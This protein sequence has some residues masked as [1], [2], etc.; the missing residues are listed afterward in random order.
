MSTADVS[1][2]AQARL[3]VTSALM[4][5][6]PGGAYQIVRELMDSGVPFDQVLLD[7]VAGAHG[8]FGTRWQVGDYSIADE[9]AATGAVETL[10]A[11]LGGSF[12]LPSNGDVIVVAAA[13][14]DHH[15]LPARLASTYLTSIGFRIRYL[16]PDME[17]LDLADYLADEKPLALL[18]SCAMPTLLRGARS[19]V[20]AAHS[21]GVPVI[22]GGH[23]FGPGGVWAHAVGADAWVASPRE[24][25]D[26]LATWEPDIETAEQL[27]PV[28]SPELS[29]ISERREAILAASIDHFGSPPRRLRTDLGLLLSAAEAALLVGDPAPLRSFTG[30]QTAIL[31]T[32]GFDAEVSGR[33]RNA[34]AESLEELAPRAADLLRS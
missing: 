21:V 8:D 28:E 15:S 4:E 19:S 20:R 31:S 16:G 1:G 26:V 24:V 25:V 32:H 23:G 17:S 2:L 18:L 14:G 34:L 30:W 10:V 9:H 22:G 11:L 12:D 7:V 3:A 5:G 33:L 13:Q 6:D 29:V 27:V